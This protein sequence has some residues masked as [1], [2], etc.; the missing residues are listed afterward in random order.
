L[1]G[2]TLTGARPK[3]VLFV[4]TQNAVR[5]PMAEGLARAAYGVEIHFESAGLR[6]A[7]TDGFAMAVMMEKGVNITRHMP[8]S[9]EELEKLDFDLVVALSAEAQRKAE[10]FF[11]SRAIPVEFWPTADA[12]RIEAARAQKLDA[13]RAVREYLAQRLSERFGG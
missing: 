3:S 13:Y 8:R 9:L 2:L 11:R 10:E 12:T 4:C 5:S 7:E 6:V 1:E